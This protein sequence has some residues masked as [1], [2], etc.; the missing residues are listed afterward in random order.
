MVRLAA[1]LSIIL[2]LGFG[3]PGAYGIR[4][5]S[6]TGEVWTFLGFPTYGGGPFERIG[7]RTTVPLLIAFLGVCGLEVV[8]GWLLWRGRRAGA[9]LAL[10]LLPIEL[11]FW[12]GFALPFGPPLGLARAILV[13]RKWSSFMRRSS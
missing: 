7:I 2:G 10:A 13:I 12:I 5:L 1:V 8:M 6:R 3:L 4:Y 9:V 11:A